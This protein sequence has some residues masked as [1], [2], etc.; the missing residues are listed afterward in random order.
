MSAEE[1]A[2]FVRKAKDLAKEHGREIGC[3][4]VGGVTC[5]RTQKEAED[6]YRHAIIENADFSA[7]DLILGMKNI[8]PESKGKEEFER[9]LLMQIES[10]FPLSPENLAWGYRPLPEISR[11]GATKQEMLVIAVKKE[12][13]EV[14]SEWREPAPQPGA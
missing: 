3:Y 14:Q 8:T 6:Y 7:I 12:V 13:M 10:A 1:T 11:N 5:R 4:T 9:L 2:G